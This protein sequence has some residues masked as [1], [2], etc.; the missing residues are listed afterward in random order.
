MNIKC[1]SLEKASVYIV[2]IL[3]KA[4]W[5]AKSSNKKRTP[6]TELTKNDVTVKIHPFYSVLISSQF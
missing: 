5:F 6:V 4:L 1:N 3:L 2:V